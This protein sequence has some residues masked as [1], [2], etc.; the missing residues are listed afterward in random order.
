MNITL[1][2]TAITDISSTTSAVV[3]D[4]SGL[5]TLFI[6]ILLALYVIEGIMGGVKDK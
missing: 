3:Y 2:E 4:L 5:M 1:P 6:G